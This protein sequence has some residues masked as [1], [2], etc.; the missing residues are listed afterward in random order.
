[1]QKTEV[2]ETSEVSISVKIIDFGL[3]RVATSLRQ[4][5]VSRSDDKTTKF[6]QMIIGTLSYA[7]PEQF[8]HSE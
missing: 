6:G 4:E 2:L 8:V 5:G 1:M 7:P 3:A